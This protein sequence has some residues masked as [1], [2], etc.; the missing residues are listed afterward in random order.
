MKYMTYLRKHVIN[1]NLVQRVRNGSLQ[2]VTDESNIL[3]GIV[4][5]A[6][7]EGVPDQEILKPA[8]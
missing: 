8:L 5:L 3:P 1:G 2:W 7:E 6:V 4:V